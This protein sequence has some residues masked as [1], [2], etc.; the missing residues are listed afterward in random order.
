MGVM[1]LSDDPSIFRPVFHLNALGTVMM[2]A[3]TP[4]AGVPVGG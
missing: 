1:M 3:V 4:R 2:G